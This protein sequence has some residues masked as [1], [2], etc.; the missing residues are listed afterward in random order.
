VQEVQVEPVAP[1]LDLICEG[2]RLVSPD[3]GTALERGAVV[4][5]ALYAKLAAGVN[6]PQ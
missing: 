2:I 5:D 4:Y 1:G 6:Q 3:D